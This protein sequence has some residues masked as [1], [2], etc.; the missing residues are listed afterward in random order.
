MHFSN[1]T[2]HNL[3][4]LQNLLNKNT[5]CNSWRPDDKQPA[6]YLLELA[7]IFGHFIQ[8]ILREHKKHS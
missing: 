6:S 4:S 7:L 3:F 5:K 1:F 2:T 8:N